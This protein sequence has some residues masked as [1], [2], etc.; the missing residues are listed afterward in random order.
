MD[1]KIPVAIVSNWHCMN[2]SSEICIIK[3][4]CLL[5]NST[6]L[7]GNFDQIKVSISSKD[8]HSDMGFYTET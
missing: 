3:T 7:Q 4:I 8:I 2:V 1:H 6:A 5:K